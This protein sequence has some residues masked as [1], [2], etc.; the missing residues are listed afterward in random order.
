MK[1]FKTLS[2][3]SIILV[4]SCKNQ[5]TPCFDKD[6]DKDFQEIKN[7]LCKGTWDR[8]GDEN[9]HVICADFSRDGIL[10]IRFSNNKKGLFNKET[11]KMCYRLIND[12]T[13]EISN[14]INKENLSVMGGNHTLQIIND[15]EIIIADFFSDTDNI[16]QS[17]SDLRLKK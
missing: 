11:G 15:K 1:T 5:I 4:F 10:E 14:I 17:P 9:S 8:N 6:E 2:L 13:I 16:L 7:K 3:L 12:S